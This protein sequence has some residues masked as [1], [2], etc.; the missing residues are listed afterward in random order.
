MS[1]PTPASPNDNPQR[2]RKYNISAEHELRFEI[3]SDSS[4][5]ITLTLEN[6]SAEIFGIEL[7]L[8]RPYPLPPGLNA[9]VFTWH[10]ATLSLAAPPSVMA[11]TATDTPMPA[12]ISAHYILQSRRE[13]ARVTGVPGPRC[14]VVG[15]RD[16]GKSTLVALLAAY[17]V[18]VN[19]SVTLADMD[20]SGCGAGGVVPGAITLGLVKRLDLESGGLVHRK[21]VSMMVGHGSPRHNRT[22]SDKVFD[23]MGTVL[24][25]FVTK[26]ETDP[27]TGCIVDTSGDVEGADGTASV[28]AV[29]RALRADVVFVL[30]AERLYASVSKEFEQSETETVLLAKS[31]GVVSRDDATRMA[32]R[33]R[34]IKEYFYGLDNRLSPFSTVL[35]FADVK[36]LKV[37]GV[38]AVVP[39]SVLP[40]GACS[41]LDPLKPL[42][43]T[44]LAETL[45]KILGVSQALVEEEVLTAP[46]YGFVHVVK[47]DH[48]RNTMTI[49][50]PSPGK[51]PSNFLL[52][53]DTKWIE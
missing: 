5:D 14:V 51:I 22:V 16:C 47:V 13:M 41:T 50:A 49:L 15:P 29:I 44:M 11:Y 40:I 25:S 30:G 46:V 10:G 6:G 32:M 4:P 7:A 38:A 42:K 24:D 43:V 39:D 1:A 19:G 37:G 20:P 36:V 8:S 12:Y 3:P 23:T 9:A 21:V 34:R 27:F 28:I 31:G 18:K 2:P 17:C 48:D 33:A 53:G 35:D 52:A 45:H 26:K